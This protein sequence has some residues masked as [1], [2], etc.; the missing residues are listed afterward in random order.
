MT[1]QTFPNGYPD[2]PE[3]AKQTSTDAWHATQIIK[4]ALREHVGDGDG[5][6]ERILDQYRQGVRKGMAEQMAKDMA[7]A[8]TVGGVQLPQE[9]QEV[10]AD[11]LLGRVIG[12]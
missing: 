12:R 3:S 6:D 9:E 11:W 4:E 5:E 8:W 7:A 10:I 2:E 1:M